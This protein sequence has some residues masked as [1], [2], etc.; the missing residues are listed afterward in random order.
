MNFRKMK[1]QK[2]HAIRYLFANDWW[3]REA[4]LWGQERPCIYE[5]ASTTLTVSSET[6]F[7]WL[8]NRVLRWMPANKNYVAVT[9]N[10]HKMIG[11]LE[12]LRWTPIMVG[13]ER[14]W[15]GKQDK[16]SG[17]RIVNLV[18]DFKETEKAKLCMMFPKLKL[19]FH[20]GEQQPMP[21]EGREQYGELLSIMRLMSG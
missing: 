12:D 14:N 4:S 10:E 16:A 3:L 19:I 7:N 2:Q 15:I 13:Y 5:N 11:A 9:F 20:V 18:G 8:E 6:Y 17:R 1:K 21:D